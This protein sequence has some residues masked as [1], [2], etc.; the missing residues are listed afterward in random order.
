MPRPRTDLAREDEKRLRA[1]YEAYRAS[2]KAVQGANRALEAELRRL[3]RRYPVAAIA[4]A[5]K[6]TP[7]AVWK[8]L[9]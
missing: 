3:R 4:R 2:Q 1:V 7:A 5:L 9:K 6:V 8:R